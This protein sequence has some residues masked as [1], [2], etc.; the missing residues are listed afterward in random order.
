MQQLIDTF[1]N[2][3]SS[4]PENIMF[5]DTMAFIDQHYDARACAFRNGEV[6]NAEGENV[7][8]CK[9]LSFAKMH[10]LTEQQTLLC[11]GEHYRNVL[12]EPDG[13]SHQNIRQFQKTGWQGVQFDAQVLTE[14]R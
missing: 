11:F 9:L 3:L 7:G 1:K 2:K 8:S 6:A 12:N 13:N 14:K 4:D 10:N 5:D